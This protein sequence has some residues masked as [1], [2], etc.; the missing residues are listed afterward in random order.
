MTASIWNTALS[1]AYRRENDGQGYHVDAG[2]P[3]G[4]TNYGVTEGT[5]ADACHA[6]LV[7]GSLV[8]ATRD[9]LALVLR[10]MFWDAVHGDQLPTGVDLVVFDHGMV[11][12]PGHAV[13]LLQA[14]VGVDADGAIG[15]VTLAA[16]AAHDPSALAQAFTTAA[17]KYFASLDGAAMFGGGWKR[18]ANDC[19]ALAL[20]LIKGTA[21]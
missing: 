16:I 11:A 6:G 3:G 20:S 9:A 2:D 15:P 17:E 18:R 5:W 12:G 21:S 4:G 19:Q 8:N 10:R 1:F 7:S 14:Q 13:R